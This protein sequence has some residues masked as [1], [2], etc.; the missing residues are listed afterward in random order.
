MVEFVVGLLATNSTD[1]LSAEPEYTAPMAT[2]QTATVSSREEAAQMGEVIYEQRLK[3]LLEPACLGQIV[4]IHLP[5]Q[6]YFLGCTFL[7]AADLLQQ[8]YP[9]AAH[10]EVYARGVGQR[11]VIRARTPRV[12]GKQA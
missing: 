2:S 10:G 1:L 8:K 5:S 12:N 4:A 9:N 11:A 6:D 3:A 7:E